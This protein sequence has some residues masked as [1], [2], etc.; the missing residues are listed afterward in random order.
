MNKQLLIF[1]T[2]LVFGSTEWANAQ[3]T[4]ADSTR[5]QRLLSGEDTLRINPEFQR[6]IQEGTFLNL[7]KKK[8]TPLME[9]ER[10]KIAVEIDFSQFNIKPERSLWKTTEE[11]EQLPPQVFWLYM[12]ELDEWDQWGRKKKKLHPR[13]N[14]YLEPLR[15]MKKSKLESQDFNHVISTAFSPHYRRL[16]KNKKTATAYKTYDL[17]SPEILARRREYLK[18][19]PEAAL[20]EEE[21]N[22][23]QNVVHEEASDSIPLDPGTPSAYLLMPGS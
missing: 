5:L 12:P 21:L 6:S 23:R 16:E 22:I 7:D 10:E 18:K 11:I 3:W 9:P 8:M 17:P 15:A 19:H 14:E 1:Y 13:F 4:Q 2:L 20:P